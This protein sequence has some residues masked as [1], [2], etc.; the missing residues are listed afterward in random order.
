MPLRQLQGASLCHFEKGDV[1]IAQD[2]KID[3]LYY[4]IK[5]SV[6]REL[7]TPNG[8]EFILTIKSAN[9]SDYIRSLIGVL[10]L[11]DKHEQYAIF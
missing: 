9:K 1:L 8:T 7:L 2:E 11:Y 5:G 10:I 3:Y 6:H 4:L